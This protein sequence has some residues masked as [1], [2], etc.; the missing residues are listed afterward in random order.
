V[1]DGVVEAIMAEFQFPTVE[2]PVEQRAVAHAYRDLLRRH[3]NALPIV[4]TWPIQTTRAWGA[5]E[6]ILEQLHQAGVNLLD[7]VALL[8]IASALVNGLVLA[9]VGPPPGGVPDRSSEEKLAALGAISP[10][11]FPH[12]ATALATGGVPDM[13]RAFELAIDLLIRGLLAPGGLAQTPQQREA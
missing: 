8:Q 5:L 13:D 3:P 1:L 10:E 12:L 4:T 7:A 11:R 9:E 6:V 2:G